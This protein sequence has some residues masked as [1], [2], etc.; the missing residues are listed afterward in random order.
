VKHALDI[1]ILGRQCGGLLDQFKG[2]SVI[3]PDVHHGEKGRLL[4]EVVLRDTNAKFS[5]V[6]AVP[7]HDDVTLAADPGS[8]MLGKLF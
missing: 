8:E 3:D 2:L 6:A 7:V 5:L 4:G 1:R